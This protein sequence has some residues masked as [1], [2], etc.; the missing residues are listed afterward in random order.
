MD[1][2]TELEQLIA[3]YFN[4]HNYKFDGIELTREQSRLLAYDLIHTLQQIERIQG[5][6][7]R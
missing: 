7:R 2:A 5:N 4:G 6:R 1:V 3:I